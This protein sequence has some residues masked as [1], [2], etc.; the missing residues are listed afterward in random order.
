[1]AWPRCAGR[2]CCASSPSPRSPR[3][4]RSPGSS[5]PMPS[6]AVRRW[7]RWAWY[8]WPGLG[9]WV[10]TMPGPSA[11]AS[12]GDRCVVAVILGAAA[13]G[14][15]ASRWRRPP[16]LAAVIVAAVAVRA[17][18]G[19]TGD[20]LGAIEQVAE[21]ARP[22]RRH[23]PR[24]CATRLVVHWVASAADGVLA[25]QDR[26]RIVR[27]RRSR[28][29]GREGW[30]GIRNDQA[31]IFLRQMQVGDQAII[32]HSNAKPPGAAGVGEIVGS[33]EPDPTQ[34]DPRASTTTPRRDPADPRGTGSRSR[35]FASCDSS[36]WTN[37]ARCPNSPS[38]VCSHGA[39]GCRSCPSRTT[40]ST[41]SSAPGR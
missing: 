38:H 15:W 32:Y 4:R 10:P 14:W 19:I 39:T 40:S 5:P 25:A 7:W 8:R 24:A 13:T 12:A 33:A 16:P 22:R 17:F 34:F 29:V 6:P 2:S 28:R 18:G 41:P 37:C 1:M 27:L 36:R 20:V 3:Q 21:C 23:R 11:T 9:V 26:A 31:R 35:R 30:D